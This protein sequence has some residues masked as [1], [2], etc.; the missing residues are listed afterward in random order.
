[1]TVDLPPFEWDWTIVTD[2]GGSEQLFTTPRNAVAVVGR[3]RGLFGATDTIQVHTDPDGL[4]YAI[5]LLYAD[6]AARETLEQRLRSQYGAPGTRP[7]VPDVQIYRSAATSLW[8]RPS[9][10]A[11]AEVLLSGRGR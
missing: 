10:T 1:M 4:V 2:Q 5:R 3:T 9:P 7:G 6:P 8:L 11:R